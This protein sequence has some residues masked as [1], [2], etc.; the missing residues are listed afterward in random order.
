MEVCGG[1]K[2]ARSLATRGFVA[3]SLRWFLR[4]ARRALGLSRPVVVEGGPWADAALV[5]LEGAPRRLADCAPSVRGRPLV[6]NFG[7]WT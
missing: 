1:N 7:S 5:S 4:D 2:F 6:L 3:S